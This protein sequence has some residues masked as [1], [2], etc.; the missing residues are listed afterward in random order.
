[1]K[2]NVSEKI[3]SDLKKDG[4]EVS[5]IDNKIVARKQQNLLVVNKHTEVQIRKD[6]AFLFNQSSHKLSRVAGVP[7]SEIKK[8]LKYELKQ[9]KSL[10]DTFLVMC[11]KYNWTNV[12]FSDYILD[13]H[14]SVKYIEVDNYDSINPICT[15]VFLEDEFNETFV[16][17]NL[18]ANGLVKYFNNL[19]ITHTGLKDISPSL[20]KSINS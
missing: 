18:S 9:R 16:V 20:Y 8:L 6:Y 12:L 14:T 15:F 2:K 3:V 11:E 5:Q 7:F 1:M 10:F 17:M 13:D 4:F 19:K